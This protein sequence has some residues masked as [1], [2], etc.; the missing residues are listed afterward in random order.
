MPDKVPLDNILH[1]WVSFPLYGCGDLCIH[2]QRHSWDRA[3]MLDRVAWH[4]VG[5]IPKVGYDHG[6]MQT[7][8]Y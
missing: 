8:H 5:V 6:F 3:L 1:S 7:T 2:Q 4:T